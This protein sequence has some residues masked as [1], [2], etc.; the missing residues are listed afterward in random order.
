MKPLRPQN[1]MIA[2]IRRIFGKPSEDY[3]MTIGEVLR[4]RGI[5]TGQQLE[6]ALAVQK[7]KLDQ[8]GKAVRLGQIIVELGYASEKELVQAI[9]IDYKI[10]VNSLSDDIK[11]LVKAKR[12]TFIEG[13]PAPRIPIWLQLF[14][15]TMIIVIATI[16]VLGFV[17][18]REQRTRLYQQTVK[19]GMVSLNYF[20]S[21]APVP[22]LDDNILRLNTLIR[23]ATEVEG[24]LYAIIVDR[25]KIIKAHTDLDQ[26]GHPFSMFNGI[27]EPPIHP[28][29]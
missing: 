1:I 2:Q 20:G 10:S 19:I 13:L 17:I 22:L 24:L 27:E 18:L 23:E 4:Q 15:A 16:A 7:E 28:Y 11:G 9:N 29:S 14:A 25:N 12:G 8:L 26:I 6:N 21:N 3:R 5:I